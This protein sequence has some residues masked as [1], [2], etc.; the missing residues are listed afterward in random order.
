MNTI[1]AKKTTSLRL[2]TRLYA[3]I[4]K[5]AKNQNRS[6][7]NFIETILFDAT[8]YNEPNAETK[9][10][11]AEVENADNNLKRYSDLNSLFEDLEK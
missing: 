2:S 8:G 5:M 9:K 7:N 1:N 4:A 10:A 6:V 11:I 3:H